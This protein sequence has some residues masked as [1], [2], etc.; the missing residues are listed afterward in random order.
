MKTRLLQSESKRRVKARSFPWRR[1]KHEG[2]RLKEKAALKEE[3]VN[4][5]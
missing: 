2:R 4:L 5:A 1:W 3:E